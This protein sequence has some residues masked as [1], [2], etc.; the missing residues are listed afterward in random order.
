MIEN[1]NEF[2]EKLVN[3]DRIDGEDYGHYPFQMLVETKDGSNEM[4]ALALGGDVEA[5][6]RRFR[7]Y[8]NNEAKKIF[9]SLDFPSG[10]DIENDFVA[11]FSFVDNKVELIAIPYSPET[12]ETFEKI[13]ESEFLTKIKEQ[14]LEYIK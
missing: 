6:Y 5:C 1:V 12:G 3:I 14:F 13:Y 10:G 9:L 11:V 4:N 8:K 2:V 7:E